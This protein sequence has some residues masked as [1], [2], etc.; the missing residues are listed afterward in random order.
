MEGKLGRLYKVRIL[1]GGSVTRWL[2][3]KGNEQRYEYSQRPRNTA[4]YTFSV[5]CANIFL[6]F[7]VIMLTVIS[8]AVI[9]MT[10]I[11]DT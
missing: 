1:F 4:S 8:V 11:T 6:L 3:G 5:T 2:V 7:G 9:P 10:S